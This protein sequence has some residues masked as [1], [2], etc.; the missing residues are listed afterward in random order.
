MTS[1]ILRHTGDHIHRSNLRPLTD[2][3]IT[4]PYQIEHS[5]TVHYHFPLNGE[6][7]KTLMKGN[8]A[9]ISNIS[10]Y[11]WYEWMKYLDNVC[12]YPDNKRVLGRYLGPAPDVG[13]MMTSKILRHTGDH[14]PRSTLFPLKD[15]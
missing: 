6:V 12:T 9:E 2:W 13:S 14:I 7:P 3:E 8:G 11:E 4:Y 1:K 5:H 15:C 10:E